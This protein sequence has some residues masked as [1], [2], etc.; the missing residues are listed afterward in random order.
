M[1]WLNSEETHAKAQKG[2][3]PNRE[4]RSAGRP[5]PRRQEDV[6]Q[7]NC[8]GR[9]GMVDSHTWVHSLTQVVRWPA[10]R[11]RHHFPANSIDDA[12]GSNR[13]RT[14]LGASVRLR[15]TAA[16]QELAA[17]ERC[18]ETRTRRQR[19]RLAHRSQGGAAATEWLAFLLSQSTEIQT[20][21]TEH[22]RFEG[23]PLCGLFSSSVASVTRKER[24]GKTTVSPMALQRLAERSSRQ[25]AG[26][27]RDDEMPVVPA[28][29]RPRQRFGL[30]GSDSTRIN[31]VALNPDASSRTRICQTP[32]RSLG[33]RSSR[34]RRAPS[35]AP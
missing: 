17:H 26:H 31:R 12:H 28:A 22:T 20:E 14:D 1:A 27:P 11:C 10:R 30:L 33:A 23:L 16:R 24:S 15:I 21:D 34:R 13:A 6:G 9:R 3:R 8:G 5:R 18:L 35:R 2:S 32:G 29:V 7:E 25:R 4:S 19:V